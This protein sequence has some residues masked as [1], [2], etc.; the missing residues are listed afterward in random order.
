MAKKQLSVLRNEVMKFLEEKMYESS[1][2]NRYNI[3]W[4]YL[5]EYMD[6]NDLAL[7]SREVG[8]S[9]LE[10]RYDKPYKSLTRNQ[11]EKVRHVIVLSDY[12]EKS[13]ISR[14]RS[15]VPP[16]IFEGDLGYI[17]NLFIDIS[18]KDHRESTIKRFKERIKSFYD[19]MHFH[20]I[21]VNDI[22]PSVLVQYISD[23]NKQK[24]PIDRNNT[25]VT[26]RV[27]FKYLCQCNLLQNNNPEYWMAILKPRTVYQPKIQSVYQKEE[28]EAMLRAI[29][30]ENPQG[31]RDYAMVLLAAR[32]GLR[33][34]DII[35]F[36]FCN[37]DWEHNCITLVQQ[38]TAKRVSLPLSEEVGDA[39][40]DYLKYGRPKVDEPFIFI[41]AHAPYGKLSSNGMCKTISDYFRLAGVQFKDRKRGP[42]S[43][44]HSLASNLL[45]SNTKLPV[46]SEIL[47]HS[48]TQSTMTYLRVDMDLLRQCALEVP[49]VPSSFYDNLYE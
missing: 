28:I 38:K 34:S 40:I 19:F 9:F 7:Y 8:E 35:G 25:I 27:L 15:R 30:R 44:R 29:G 16:I 5:Q 14:C 42:H 47:G 31:K 13:F 3:T 49:C 2:I 36:R 24:K 41:T 32:Y 1:C 21:G 12:L 43:L 6:R 23:I 48:S 20:A 33:L 37:L 11:K 26:I 45:K 17:F 46:I 10:Y 4:N 22:T 18:S 39:I